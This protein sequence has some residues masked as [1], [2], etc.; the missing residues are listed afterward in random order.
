MRWHLAKLSLF[1]SVVTLPLQ[2][3]PPDTARLWLPTSYQTLFLPLREAAQAAQNLERCV[4]VLE[5]T[6]DLEQSQ[7]GRPIFRILCRQENGRNYNE[8]VDGRTFTTLTTYQPQPAPLSPE[9]LERLE[10][11]KESQRQAEREA[12]HDRLWLACARDLEPKVQ[13]MIDLIW[14]TPSPPEATYEAETYVSFFRDF[15]AKDVWGK[16]LHFRAICLAE[17]EEEVQLHILPRPR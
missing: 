8:M 17:S 11:E 4:T 15:D 5:G 6:V 9:D 13:H 2:A 3:A 7:P 1:I 10:K 16:N 12:L 14:L